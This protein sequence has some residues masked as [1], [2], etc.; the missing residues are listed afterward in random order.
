MTDQELEV[1]LCRALEHAAPDQLE[2]ILSRCG[3]Q[4][5][6]AIPLEA[7]KPKKRG[8]V[9]RWAAAAAALLLV[10]GAAF[11]GLRMQQAGA[12]TTVVSMDVNPSV[13]LRLNSREV[14]VD[15]VAL[16]ADGQVVLGDMN[17][18]GSS[19]DVAVNAI[20]GSLLRNGYVNELANS[21]LITVEDGNADRGQRLQQEVSAV[22]ANSDTNCA[23]LVQTLAQ[24]NDLQTLADQ[25]QLSLGK[26]SLIQS[27]VNQSDHLTFADLAGLSINELNLL[28]T[29]TGASSAVTATGLASDKA[30]IGAEAAKS[31]AMA[32]A[33]LQE[34]DLVSSRMEFD[35]EDGLMIYEVTLLTN[36]TEYEY[37]IN[38]STGEI[39]QF[40]MDRFSVTVSSS[41]GQEGA[42]QV[43]LSHA[44]LSE[45][46]VTS[47]VVKADLGDRQP[48][49]EVEFWSGV[50]QYEYDIDAVTGSILAFD[51]EQRSST[52]PAGA[53]VIGQDAA[54]Q[55]ALSHAGLSSADIASIWAEADLNDRTPHYEVKF[56]SNSTEYEYEIDAVTG[57]VLGYEMEG[58]GAY[59][60]SGG[61]SGSAGDI[62]QEAAKNAAFQHAGVSASSVSNVKV[63]ADL[64]DNPPHYE[65]EFWSGTV[66]YE[67]KVAA[68][69]G[70]ILSYEREDHP[71]AI[72]P[73]QAIGRDA[74]KQA[75][76][77]HAGLSESQV[78]SL[79]VKEE[80]DDDRPHYEV[81]FRSGWMEYEY[82]IDAVTGAVLKFESDYDD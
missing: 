81:E 69:D 41:I 4:T 30:Y 44:G 75:A 78:T 47:L 10:C 71:N 52:T 27:I 22:L 46:Q 42:K 66:E 32:H 26:A 6:K 9:T 7:A 40:E 67:Y 57:A 36:D 38:A 64:R 82:E 31:A 54:K 74:A 60:P 23:V 80:L 35:C 11:G 17:L 20:L 53:S 13:E 43:A 48:H 14:V 68:A 51:Q 39:V 21:I 65:V 1:K 5:G 33:G 72:S 24:S 62:G 45:S 12:V 77:T 28:Y 61:A 70:A 25:Y 73:S 55:A 79:K 3:P 19:L 15:A 59:V 58:Y 2:A 29:S 49:Y 18:K 50:T 37:D 76:L 63:E 8:F 16:N 56:W 34:S